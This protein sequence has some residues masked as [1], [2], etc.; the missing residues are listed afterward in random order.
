MAEGFNDS[1]WDVDRAGARGASTWNVGPRRGPGRWRVLAMI[2]ALMLLMATGYWFW[3][4]YGP[5]GPVNAGGV[6]IQALKEDAA[7]VDPGAGFVLKS[8]EPMSPSAVSAY[9]KVTPDFEYRI[10][11]RAGGREYKITPVAPLAANTVY[12]ISFDPSGK[13]REDYSWAFQTRGGFKVLSTLPRDKSNRVPV[14][15]GIEFNLSQEKF[16]VNEVPQ[17]F[18]ITPDTAG[19]FEKHR[20]ILVFVPKK[21]L[22]YGTLYTVTLKKGLPMAGSDEILAEDCTVRFETAPEDEGASDKQVQLYWGDAQNGFSTWQAPVLQAYGYCSSPMPVHVDVYRYPDYRAYKSVMA[23]L[24]AIP[25]WSDLTRQRFRDDVK[26]L[27]KACSFDTEL[28]S[29]DE[30]THYLEF[31]SPLDAGYYAAEITV[32]GKTRQ[33]WLQISDLAAYVVQTRGGTVFWVNDLAKKGP[34]SGVKIYVDSRKLTLAGDDSGVAM[35][36]ENL[37]GNKRDYARAISGD[38]EV[39]IPL[40]AG[41]EEWF[42]DLQ[43][44]SSYWKYLYLDRELYRPGDTVKFWGVLKPRMQDEE[45]KTAVLELWGGDYY[46][47]GQSPPLIRKTVALDGA[48]FSGQIKL[49]VLKTGY[50]NLSL[51]IG[52][53]NVLNRGFSVQTYQKPAYRLT[54]TP[55]KAAVYDGETARFKVKAAFFEGTPAPGLLLNYQ[56]DE[57][58]G[59]LKTDSQGEAVISCP[60]RCSDEYSGYE[61]H[62]LEV[63]ARLPEAGEIHASSPVLVFRSGVYLSSEVKVQKDRFDIRVKLN[64]VDLSRVNAGSYPSEDEFLAGPVAGA[65]IKGTLY[66]EVWIKKETGQRYDFINKRVEKTYQY[67]T[68]EHKLAEFSGLTGKDGVY[69]YEGAIQPGRSYYAMVWTYDRNGRRTASKIYIYSFNPDNSKYYYLKDTAGDKKYRPG[70]RVTLMVMENEQELDPAGAAVLFYRGQKDIETCSAGQ[71]SRYQFTFTEKDIPNTNVGGVV[72]DGTSYYEAPPV[73]VAFARE[74]RALHVSVKPDKSEYRPGEKVNLTVNVTDKKGRPVPGAHVN[75]NLVD[76]ALFNLQEQ[77]VDLLGELYGDYIALF[78]RSGGTH[79]R[80]S[81]AAGAEKGGE[82]E[83]ARQDFRDTVLFTNLKTDDEGRAQA[84]FK[85][86]DNLTSWR[87]TYQAVTPDLNAGS[88]VRDLPVRLPFFAD[89]TMNDTYLVG[90]APVILVR[91]FGSRISASQTVQYQM[92]LVDPSGRETRFAKDWRPYKPYDWKLPALREGTY[93]VSVTTRCGEYKDTVIRKFTV[94]NSQMERTVSAHYLLKPGR[95]SGNQSVKPTT[96]VFCDYEKSRCLEGL[97]SLSWLNGSRVEHQLAVREAVKLIE[98]YFPDEQN[99]REI[100]DD[101]ALIAYQQRDGGISIVPYAESDI[102]VSAAVA[103]AAPEYFDKRALSGY[104]YSILKQAAN[105]LERSQALLGLAALQEPVLLQV[106]EEIQDEDLA[107]EVRVILARALVELGDGATARELYSDLIRKYGQDLGA[108]MR[109][110]AGR[111]QDEILQATTGMAVLAAQLNQ[112]EKEKLYQYLLN[113]PGEEIVNVLEQLKIL[114]YS[115]QY[116]NSSPVE[117]AYELG[118]RTTTVTLKGWETYRL[119]VAPADMQGLKII[120]VKGKVGVAAYYTTPAG[121]GPQEA[122]RDL[123]LKRRYLVNGAET[124]RC[125]RTDLVRVEIKVE[126]S[127]RAPGGTYEVQD[128]LPAGLAYV[129]ISYRP[130]EQHSMTDYWWY[131]PS[132]VEGRRLTF[133]V[134]KRFVNADARKRSTIVYY[135]RVAAPGEFTAEAPVISHINSSSVCNRGKVQ[136]F[137]IE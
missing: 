52:N 6:S 44:A 4:W 102:A 40:E 75:L 118:G 90:D 109:I 35:T 128:V 57:S 33:V 89:L 58:R 130:Y 87:I 26:R 31:P 83:S 122:D 106:K 51:K 41:F 72:F 113:N 77:Y 121:P 56:F 114:S 36:R 55:E 42:R 64:Q 61:Y 127:S 24:D 19:H 39:L 30:Y 86:P 85:L 88:G 111:D 94:V 47:D 2:G 43:A 14:N 136:R 45:I 62:Y 15:T 101:D 71:R 93:T 115:L 27:A 74:D 92:K 97:Y 29:A 20:N 96:L 54:V 59:E 34:A 32:G 1:L 131:Y 12:K 120:K 133:V 104:F 134:D 124:L 105:D 137:V 98:K 68:E 37:M 95:V 110:N 67:T 79:V 103:A 21:P 81:L 112:P 3:N 91:G 119:T 80:L 38:K 16:S 13:G 23:R 125:K 60:A 100:E 11:K 22:A 63:S 84:S 78:T 135:A 129:N 126:L 69:S 8:P 116:I 107:P 76:E 9:L 70:D 46:D 82:G 10:I 73:A 132:Q 5:P 50:Y 108:A 25:A 53:N 66:E 48:V 28:K 99:F 7:G 123:G 18:S 65:V 49:P 17:Y 117:F